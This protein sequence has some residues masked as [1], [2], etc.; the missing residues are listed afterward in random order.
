MQ[1]LECEVAV[2]HICTLGEG[3][4]WDSRN[5]CIFWIDISGCLICQFFPD[6]GEFKTCKLESMIGSI[7]IRE[8]GGLVVA[9]QN[10]FS[11]VNPDDGNSSFLSD[12]EAD[13]LTNRFND[14]KC[15]PAGRFWAGTMST[16]GQRKSGSLYKL[17][18]DHSITMM[19]TDVSCSNGLAWSKNHKTLY[20][21]Y[22]PTREVV[23][24]DYELTTGSIANKKNIFTFSKE[25]G[26]PDG[27]T[28]DSEGM[29]WIALWN[30][31]KVMRIDPDT[32][33][34]ILNV[35]LPVS[36]VTSCTF[37]GD[38]LDDL[39]IT[40]ARSGLPAED[41][42]KQPLAGSLFVVKKS[43]FNGIESVPYKG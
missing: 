25:D 4:V 10:G 43:G 40:S 11:F 14:G 1:Q 17:N 39:Y 35:H 36:Q 18:E 7:A 5:K 29:L 38:N 8:S 16:I 2:N 6:S 22:T 15:D 21:I 28:I 31:W 33:E 34:N 30:G 20:F 24:F 32:G 26:V 42:E 23:A 9:S 13:L 41:L 19:L 3:P 37:G 27:M 12:P